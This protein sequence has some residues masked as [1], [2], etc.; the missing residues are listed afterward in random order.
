MFHQCLFHL[1]F[2]H[3]VIITFI[4]A[5]PIREEVQPSQFDMTALLP[6]VVTGALLV[7]LLLLLAGCLCCPYANGLK[8]LG[9][10][11]GIALSQRTY[12]NLPRY[13][14]ESTF[15]TFP[16]QDPLHNQQIR[17]FYE[18]EVTFDRLP[19]IHSRKP[20]SLPS[21]R[22]PRPAYFGQI[23]SKH[24]A[25]HEWFGNNLP[26]SQ[27]RYIRELGSGWFGKVVE[28][29]IRQASLN[30]GKFQI[31]VKILREDASPS[32]HN[33]F[34]NEVEYFRK[35]HHPNIVHVI[36]QCL[37]ED[38]FLILMEF[39]SVNLK[40]FLIDKCSSCKGLDENVSLLS[41]AV[42]IASGLQHIHEQGFVHLD[43]AARNC[44]VTSDLKVKIGDYGT[45]VEQFKD[46]YYCLGDIAIPVRW[47]SPESLQCTESSI[48]TKVLT[49]KTNVWSFGIVLWELF[50]FGKLPYQELSNDDVIQKVIIEKTVL[51]DQPTTA[52]VHSDKIYQ[53]MKLCWV[54]SEEELEMHS[55]VASLTHLYKNKNVTSIGSEDFES[56]WQALH[57]IPREYSL[58]FTDASSHIRKFENDFIPETTVHGH[59]QKIDSLMSS[60]DLSLLP[61]E[62]PSYESFVIGDE[63]LPE[64]VS[65]S[66]QNLS[67]SIEGSS[68]QA[69]HITGN[70]CEEIPETELLSYQNFDGSN[71][72]ESIYQDGDNIPFTGMTQLMT[73]TGCNKSD[74]ISV[75]LAEE[76]SESLCNLNN[77]FLT[78]RDMFQNDLQTANRVQEVLEAS[79]TTTEINVKPVELDSFDTHDKQNDD[80]NKS[81]ISCSFKKTGSLHFQ[82]TRTFQHCNS[83]KDEDFSFT[84][85]LLS[86]KQV[87]ELAECDTENVDS[88]SD[89]ID[90]QGTRHKNLKLYD[91]TVN[92]YTAD[93]ALTDKSH[94]SS[95]ELDGVRSDSYKTISENFVLEENFSERISTNLLG[96]D[97]EEK[98]DSENLEKYVSAQLVINNSVED[99]LL[100]SVEEDFKRIEHTSFDTSVETERSFLH[101]NK[102]NSSAQFDAADSMISGE[103]SFVKNISIE[104]FHLLE[105]KKTVP[106][107]QTCFD[108]AVDEKDLTFEKSGFLFLSDNY[109]YNTEMI[110]VTSDYVGKDDSFCGLPESENQQFGAYKS[111]LGADLL[112]KDKQKLFG[113]GDEFEKHESRGD[114]V[115][116]EN[117]SVIDDLNKCSTFMFSEDNFNSEVEEKPVTPLKE[118]L[119]N[120]EDDVQ[121]FNCE[122]GFETKK[123]QVKNLGVEEDNVERLNVCCEFV[124]LSI[125]K[126]QGTVIDGDKSIINLREKQMIGTFQQ[127][128]VDSLLT[129][130]NFICFVPQNSST[131]SALEE[132][133][134]DLTSSSHLIAECSSL[135]AI[136]FDEIQEDAKQPRELLDSNMVEHTSS[137]AL[138]P[139]FENHSVNYVKQDFCG[140]EL[141]T[142]S[143]EVY[144]DVS[145]SNAGYSSDMDD[146]LKVK[147]SINNENFQVECDKPQDEIVGNIICKQSSQKILSSSFKLKPAESSNYVSQQK[148]NINC[149]FP[150]MDIEETDDKY[151]SGVYSGITVSSTDEKEDSI[152]DK[153]ELA[154]DDVYEQSNQK[155]SSAFH[156][157]G[158]NKQTIEKTAEFVTE[159]N[160]SSCVETFEHMYLGSSTGVENHNSDFLPSN[161]TEVSELQENK[162]HDITVEFLEF[163]EHD[164]C[165]PTSWVHKSMPCREFSTVNRPIRQ[166][167]ESISS[168]S[169][170]ICEKSESEKITSET[171]PVINSDIETMFYENTIISSP[172]ILES[173]EESTSSLAPKMANIMAV[174]EEVEMLPP[175]EN[176]SD[177]EDDVKNDNCT[178]NTSPNKDKTQSDSLSDQQL[179]DYFYVNSGIGNASMEGNRS[180]KVDKTSDNFF[181]ETVETTQRQSE[182]MSYTD[183]SKSHAEN[184]L[185]DILDNVC[186]AEKIGERSDVNESQPV[187]V[188]TDCILYGNRKEGMCSTSSK[189][190]YFDSSESLHNDQGTFG[191]NSAV[192]V[193]HEGDSEFFKLSQEVPHI[194]V[195]GEDNGVSSLTGQNNCIS[196][197]SLSGRV[198]PIE[199]INQKPVANGQSKVIQEMPNELFGFNDKLVYSSGHYSDYPLVLENPKGELIFEG[200]H[201]LAGE[202][203]LTFFSSQEIDHCKEAEV[204]RKHQ[205]QETL[206]LAESDLPELEFTTKE[207]EK[208]RGVHVLHTVNYNVHRSEVESDTDDTSSTG[209]SCSSTS[210]SFECLNLKFKDKSSEKDLEKWHK[211]DGKPEEEEDNVTAWNSSATPTRSILLSPEKKLLGMKKSVS[212]HEDHP[213]YVYSYP[214]EVDSDDDLE[215]VGN[216]EDFCW[217]L[218]YGNYADWDF[219]PSLDDDQ[220]VEEDV[221]EVEDLKDSYNNFIRYKPLPLSAHQSTSLYTIV[222]ITDEELAETGE[223]D[224]DSIE[225]LP[226]HPTKTFSYFQEKEECPEIMKQNNPCFEESFCDENDS[227]SDKCFHSDF[228]F[229]IS[230]ICQENLKYKLQKFHEIYKEPEFSVDESIHKD[231]EELE[232][233]IESYVDKNVQNQHKKL[234]DGIKPFIDRDMQGQNVKL[235]NSELLIDGNSDNQVTV[236]DSD[237]SFINRNIQSQHEILDGSYSHGNI[238]NH[239][240]ELE[241]S[242]ESFIDKNT[243]NQNKKLEDETNL[244]IDRNI[245]KQQETREDDT[246]SLAD[247]N[248]WKKQEKVGNDTESQKLDDTEVQT[249]SNIHNQHKKLEDDMESLG[250]KSIHNQSEKR[251]QETESP[252]DKY[253]QYEELKNSTESLVDRNIKGQLEKGKDDV[254]SLADRNIQSQYEEFEDGTES[255]V[256]RNFD[257]QHENGEDD[258]ELLADR[259][260][261]NQYEELE[262]V[263]SSSENNYSETESSRDESLDGIVKSTDDSDHSEDI[264]IEG[265]SDFEYDDDVA[266]TPN[267]MAI[268]LQWPVGTLPDAYLEDLPIVDVMDTILEEPEEDLEELEGD[269]ENLTAVHNANNSEETLSLNCSVEDTKESLWFRE[270]LESESQCSNIKADTCKHNSKIDTT[271]KNSELEIHFEVETPVCGYN[272][273]EVSEP[274]QKFILFEETCR[275]SHQFQEISHQPYET[276]KENSTFSPTFNNAK[277]EISVSS[278]SEEE[279]S[280]HWF[281]T[282]DKTTCQFDSTM[283]YSPGQLLKERVN[284]SEQ[285]IDIFTS[286][287][288]VFSDIPVI[289]VS[290]YDDE[291][292]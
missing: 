180:L 201:I 87:L 63:D 40:T 133:T 172:K 94:T 90:F 98:K 24:F 93:L 120:A 79:V 166:L 185:K 112:W 267:T 194:L 147:Q 248:I 43:L 184:Y 253:S 155:V 13:S 199:F 189:E 283:K 27:I 268:E 247:R 170:N 60:T 214:P 193:I 203:S 220:D 162:H 244:V 45:T 282:V 145:G 121:D 288:N 144:F 254:E 49:K 117:H 20:V 143:G 233:Y 14:V 158:I 126:N 256:D 140:N 275:S 81:A 218:D 30:Q 271:E 149:D 50:E 48:E 104:N 151:I 75:T 12:H 249:D 229:E 15:N 68:T 263:T 281:E 272:H 168:N 110:A 204:R 237:E 109:L 287:E 148:T 213:V 212:F 177:N 176:I 64:N 150:T 35:L 44:L 4:D 183:I 173:V 33:Y 221:I 156:L 103:N 292:K 56:K 136:S 19:E 202:E 106:V 58:P 261:Q 116:E 257:D 175:C 18:D 191:S 198:S 207:T 235:N 167:S 135:K 159:D 243:Q 215:D 57:T 241:D 208:K 164:Y 37:E 71:K 205:N 7:C 264:G 270:V 146:V 125:I 142:S 141:S 182:K 29:E 78:S 41:M 286:S 234:E 5:V 55:L 200:E 99:G 132:S 69:E 152:D 96:K 46:D 165:V 187:L 246:E 274:D 84:D 85:E 262:D 92:L 123:R 10:S 279:A 239:H 265:D 186:N 154:G 231:P 260:I 23:P 224:L 122:N 128:N 171:I 1:I 39:V 86:D 66:L 197:N 100:P 107:L 52:C 285:E 190:D 113:Y 11:N 209:T 82:S 115:S 195:T 206:I 223:D 169:H 289:I 111:K 139:S 236:P 290:S 8:N 258:M 266:D 250:C 134:E 131:S 80:L 242:T 2:L 91:T 89:V 73:S 54:E 118:S 65:P 138:K 232:N 216:I 101:K 105:N 17:Q 62:I 178:S 22:L 228:H 74:I 291:C 163:E 219:Q 61:C 32:E 276:S 153:K 161:Y 217:N 238:Q 3:N 95:R 9:H 72:S 119:E 252:T 157:I 222:G 160:T 226:T 51:L 269:N 77:T 277:V 16:L 255:L 108:K 230:G 21:D 174:S 97:Y 245:W 36:G 67:R 102:K 240:K 211:E 124:D 181:D 225:V 88:G 42:D 284:D 70:T 179:E 127:K 31:V 227:H 38:P 129:E 188:K 26:R 273:K 137:K 83:G 114:Y 192:K 53:V 25:L 76:T 28:G 47:C 259:N 130:N 251:D 6:G 210:G 34:L 59:A 280:S 196:F 278:N